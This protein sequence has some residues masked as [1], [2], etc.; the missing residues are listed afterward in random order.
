MKPKFYIIFLVLIFLPIHGCKKNDDKIVIDFWGMG[1]EGQAVKLLLP[2]F[3]RENPNIK[4]NVQM[5]PWTAAQEKLISAFASD[6][7]PDACQ[8]GNT[9]IPQFVSLGALENL[10]KWTDENNAISPDKYFDGIWATNIIDTSLYGVPWYLDTRVL[11]YRPDILARVGYNEPPKT[12]SELYDVSKKIKALYKKNEEKYAIF[13][14]TNEWAHYVI[15]GLQN[16]ADLLKNN[17]SY[18]NFSSPEFKEAFEFITRFL[19]EG[20]APIGIS[21]VTNVYQ[22]MASGYFAMYISGPW[23]LTEFKKWMTGDLED[24]W[25]T[26]PLPGPDTY[27]GSSLAGGSSLVMFKHSEHKEGVWKF[28]EYLSRKEIQ[29]KFYKLVNNLPAAKAVWDDPVFKNDKYMQAFFR[30]FFYV[31]PTPKIAEWEQIVFSKLQQYAEYAARGVMTV[32]EALRNM[33]QDVN[34]ILE[35]RRW[36]LAQ[37]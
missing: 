17:N 16:N 11:Y 8:L 12:W 27:P 21:Q 28:L 7:L 30:Q 2:D 29:L 6:N 32:D 23:H 15:L 25:M 18:G 20:L 35:K 4:V 36:I 3:E 26:A 33:D 10:D 5:M 24:K 37:D 31:T 9:W 19:R 22:A 13:L 14:P 1:A 34:L